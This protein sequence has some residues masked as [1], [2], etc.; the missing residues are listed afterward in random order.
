MCKSL[1][2]KRKD[3]GAHGRRGWYDNVKMNL[4]NVGFEGM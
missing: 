2:G 1:V 3:K 4:K